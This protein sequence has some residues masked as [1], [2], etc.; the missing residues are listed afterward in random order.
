MVS[1]SEFRNGMVLRLDG[2][3]Y[4]MVEFEHFKPGKGAAVVRT[5]LKG[6]KTGAMIDRTFRSGDKV[7][8]VRL[9]R[10]KMQFLYRSG[11]LY[12][13]M[14]CETY[15]QFELSAEVMGNAVKYL[16]ENEILEIL[17]AKQNTVSVALPI[18]VE[19]EVTETDPGLRGDTASGGSKP[20][21]LETGASVQVP[22]FVE[23]GDVL[24]IDTR[25]ESYVERI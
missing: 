18:F 6:V 25:T 4:F 24:K 13:F 16:K 1:T 9:E 22:L 11:D 5:R 21:V 12:C 15:D 17:V 14:D 20:A 19:L 3:L 23:R 7:D 10:R 2:D 8:D